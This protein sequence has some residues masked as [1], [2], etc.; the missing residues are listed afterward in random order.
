MYHA[1]EGKHMPEERNLKEAGATERRSALG[2][3]GRGQDEQF[4]RPGFINYCFCFFFNLKS[5]G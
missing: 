2:E 4:W 3:R 1:K 5:T